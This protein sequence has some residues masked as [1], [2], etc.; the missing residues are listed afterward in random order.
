MSDADGAWTTWQAA[1]RTK[2]TTQRQRCWVVIC[3]PWVVMSSR[4]L[5]VWF[6]DPSSGPKHAS[7][8]VAT[9][10]SLPFTRAW[11]GG[12]SNPGR[13]AGASPPRARGIPASGVLGVLELGLE[14]GMEGGPLLVGGG[15]GPG[16]LDVADVGRRG[17][18]G[19]ARIGGRIRKVRLQAGLETLELLDL[20]LQLA[21][22]GLE[23]PG[24]L[25]QARPRLGRAAPLPAP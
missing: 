13:T 24:A 14:A 12:P 15:E 8:R 25:R 17:V 22:P 11:N 16:R 7:H 19:F 4:L 1:T 23:P 6:R 10:A 3:A 21:D 20:G 5:A 9:K 18:V 2:R